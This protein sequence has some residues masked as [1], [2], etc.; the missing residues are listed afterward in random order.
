M[1]Q[2]KELFKNTVTVYLVV[3]PSS[4]LSS[5]EKQGM[6]YTQQYSNQSGIEHVTCNRDFAINSCGFPLCL[7][8][9]QGLKWH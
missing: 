1:C 3:C 4:T 8:N 5:S 2:I 9:Q 7:L 6:K